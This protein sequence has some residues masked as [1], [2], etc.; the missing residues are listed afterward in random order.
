MD[1]DHLNKGSSN[2][3]A[4]NVSKARMRVPKAHYQ[5]STA[6]RSKNDLGCHLANSCLGRSYLSKPIGHHADHSRPA[7]GLEAPSNNLK[8]IVKTFSLIGNRFEDFPQPAR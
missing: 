8:I 6:L 3:A 2:K 5:S 4:K 7:S 1:D